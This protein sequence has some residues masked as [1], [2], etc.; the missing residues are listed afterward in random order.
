[1]SHA[2]PNL[3]PYDVRDRA[4]GVRTFGCPT[5]WGS[6]WITTL[7]ESV[8]EICQPGVPA[9]CSAEDI[10]GAPAT[11]RVLGEKIQRYFAGVPVKSFAEI[12]TIH[13]WLSTAGVRGFS[14]KV[15]TAMCAVPYGETITYG[16]LAGLSGC[17]NGA[18]A[19]GTVCSRNPLPIVVP[20]HR[21]VRSGGALGEY[22]RLGTEG[23]ARLLRL[24]GVEVGDGVPRVEFA[25][26][27][28]PLRL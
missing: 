20:C 4:A 14:L 27:L 12:E 5:N 2:E 24:E 9:A 15:L 7:G 1:M 10:A 11:V 13:G 8:I 21:V 25:A 22:G 26:D 16:A 18:R 17:P 28:A 23:K 19:V 3:D 6:V